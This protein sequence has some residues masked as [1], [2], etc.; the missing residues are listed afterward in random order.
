MFKS[1]ILKLAFAICTAEGWRPKG[2]NGADDAGTLAYQNHNPGN[3]RHSD[4]EIANVGDFSVFDNDI[5]GF[6]ALAQLLWGISHG[7]NSAYPEGT[8][9]AS[10]IGT[11]T[12]LNEG[13]PEYSNY[14]TTV[15][16][17]SGIQATEL[18]KDVR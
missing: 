12:G 15:C 6:F 9:L 7:L 4:L 16:S 3:V 8:T 18:M 2:T 17:I 1:R 5:D 13:T 11:Y 10:M 14:L